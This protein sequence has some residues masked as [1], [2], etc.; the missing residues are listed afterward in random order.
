M[1]IFKT[2]NVKIYKIR[3]IVNI[4]TKK[5]SFYYQKGQ[6]LRGAEIPKISCN[7]LKKKNF[8]IFFAQLLKISKEY[9]IGIFIFS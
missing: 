1:Y 3:T 2:K 9:L 5:L 4:V 7:F 8:E 6:C